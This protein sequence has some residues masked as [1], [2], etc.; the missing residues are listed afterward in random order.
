MGPDLPTPPGRGITNGLR[1]A[2]QTFRFL[3]AIQSRFR[4]L[5]AIPLPGRGPLVLITNPQLAQTALG[6]PADFVRVPASGAARLIAE[7][8]LVQSE[9]D[10]WRTQRS[11]IAPAF[12]GERVDAYATAVG[13]HVTALTDRWNETIEKTNHATA[14]ASR[15]LHRDMTSVT[16]RAVSEVLFNHDIGFGTAREFHR[17]MRIAGDEFEFGLDTVTPTWTPDL[18]SPA[19]RD[20]AAG[21][22]D[23]AETLI[24]RRQEELTT[25]IDPPADMLGRLLTHQ[26]G[27]PPDPSDKQLRD[28]VATFLIAGHETTALALTYTHILLATRP[29]IRDRVRTEAKAV[30]QTTPPT[31][32]HAPDLEYTG[33]VFTETLRLYPPAWAV[34]RRTT[35]DVRLADYRIPQNAAVVIPLWAIHRDPTYFDNPT[36]FTPDRWETT[37]P[38]SH[39]AYFPFSTG[40]HACIGR[41]FSLT[42]ARL[43]IATI[44]RDYTIDVAS[45]AL[46]N[47]QISATLR[48]TGPVTA[49]IHPAD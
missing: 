42:G 39:P 43:A 24:N 19:F 1:F 7:H 5:A 8:G 37:D 14:G 47:L 22:I 26:N 9:G 3:E 16:L 41:Q 46:D 18:V 25:T 29:A 2:T 31:P 17:W 13:Q 32:R 45:D 38:Q 20:A 21:I 48:P 35:T 27:T 4:D 11:R 34:F 30:L 36:A 40:P 49:T 28:E 33:R 23:L 6:R 10:L 44:T 12:A 15:N